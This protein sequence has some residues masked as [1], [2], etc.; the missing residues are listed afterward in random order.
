MVQYPHQQEW[1][2]SAGSASLDDAELQPDRGVYSGLL[3]IDLPLERTA[4]RNAY[5]ASLIA[6]EKAV[7][8]MQEL[9]DSVKLQ[10]RNAL[11]KLKAA[12]EGLMTQL[13]AVA[14]AWKRV[15]STDLFLQ[16]GRAQIRDVLD[17]RED[18]LSA[19]NALTAAIVSYRTAE[20]E[21]QRDM[22]VL[23]IDENGLWTEYRDA[24]GN[25][26]KE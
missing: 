5:R 3:N 6:L 1:R 14:L 16:A 13:T 11:R 25:P 20:L 22:G 15:R 10:I 2:S 24:A 26:A 9:E 7:R 17:S 23:Q 18:L 21:L 4:E 19:Q 12:R 8:A